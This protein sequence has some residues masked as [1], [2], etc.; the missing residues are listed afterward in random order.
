MYTER[1]GMLSYDLFGSRETVNT[2]VST[3][4]YFS[5]GD[6]TFEIIL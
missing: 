4:E 3:T 1:R 2:L 6:F 5:F